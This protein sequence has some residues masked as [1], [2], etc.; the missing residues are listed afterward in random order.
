MPP[1]VKA[2]PGGGPV[3]M[4]LMNMDGKLR[5]I[6]FKMPYFNK[7]YIVSIPTSRYCCMVEQECPSG[8]SPPSG[9]LRVRPGQKIDVRILCFCSKTVLFSFFFP[10][11]RS[12][13]PPQVVYRLWRPV[14]LLYFSCRWH[15]RIPPP[16]RARPPPPPH[17]PPSSEP[18]PSCA[19]AAET[20]PPPPPRVRSAP[21]LS[22][23]ERAPQ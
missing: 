13:S 23:V 16:E 15:S 18:L 10:Y 20:P 7:S 11:S 2:G 14:V 5:I 9:F 12:D 8:L 4:G 1:L 17:A 21:G 6:L 22:L 19:L 3:A